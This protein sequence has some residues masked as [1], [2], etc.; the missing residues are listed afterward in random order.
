MRQTRVAIGSER[1]FAKSKWQIRVVGRRNR[2]LRLF[3]LV[4]TLI[5]QV[6]LPNIGLTP[7]LK[8]NPPRRAIAAF[9][10]PRRSF[11]AAEHDGTEGPFVAIGSSRIAL[12]VKRVVIA[13]AVV[14]VMH[15]DV[16]A[17][18][19]LF[20]RLRSGFPAETAPGEEHVVDEFG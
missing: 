8:R 19:D 6:Q 11:P 5:R 18:D 1:H 9:P 20:V 13:L 16:E 3:L 7:K 14:I 15:A 12:P 17:E 2:A 4:E 10:T